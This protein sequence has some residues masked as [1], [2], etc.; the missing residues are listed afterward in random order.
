MKVLVVDDVPDNRLIL[1][2][3]LTRM[4]HTPVEAK[5]GEEAVAVFCAESPDFVIMDVLMPVLDGFEAT[6]KIKALSQDHW[7]PVMFLTALN[8]SDHMIRGLEAGGDDFLS[9]PF[10]FS[11]LT[12]KV[13]VIERALGL[14]RQILEKNTSLRE[15]GARIE[16]EMLM[17][18]HVLDALVAGDRRE[19][20]CLESWIEPL[21]LFGGDL[22]LSRRAPDG[23][24]FLLLVDSQGHGL[25]AAMGLYPPTEIFHAMVDRGFD[26]ETTL[27]E[28]NRKV[29]EL[30]PPGFF[31][32]VTAV[33][34]GPGRGGTLTV[35]NCGN[36][37]AV[38]IN[39]EGKVVHRFSSR[40]LPL[41]VLGSGFQP[42]VETLHLPDLPDDPERCLYLFSDGLVGAMEEEEGDGTEQVIGHLCRTPVED[43]L[44]TLRELALQR[45]AALRRD[46]MSLV[47]MCCG[48]ELEG[49]ATGGGERGFQRPGW[50]VDDRLRP[51]RARAS[52][53]G[54]SSPNDGR[55]ECIW[56]RPQKQRRSF[57]RPGRASLKCPGPRDSGARLL[58]QKYRERIRAL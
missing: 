11:L 44:K 43:R 38:F 55:A 33:C 52:P 34:L 10:D 4:G 30:M 22:M 14:Q 28:I 13:R 12:A 48:M 54:P 26:L 50:R 21:E 1:V 6:R 29:K 16:E 42:D 7:I 27:I 2:E 32:A 47:S 45:P 36:P 58:P 46:D 57:Y 56:H 5:D 15:I 24:L 49:V 53:L 37:P 40:A 20:K 31:I 17:G 8:R 39:G 25:S 18:K 41:G 3:F 51:V 23:S 35:G 9:K 19:E